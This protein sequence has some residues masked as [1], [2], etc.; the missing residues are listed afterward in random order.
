VLGR[1][2]NIT[3]CC[4]RNQR[5][6]SCVLLPVAL[7]PTPPLDREMAMLH[8]DLAYCI[9][10][11]V[12]IAFRFLSHSPFLLIR[13]VCRMAMMDIMKMPRPPSTV[14]PKPSTCSFRN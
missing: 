6:I 9:S 4:A 13:S 5:E 10:G 14:S 3:I 12:G 7:L 2:D 1:E 8:A 11:R